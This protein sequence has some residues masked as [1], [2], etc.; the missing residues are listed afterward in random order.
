MHFAFESQFVVK[1]IA[2]GSPSPTAVTLVRATSYL[3]VSPYFYSHVSRPLQCSL[4]FISFHFISLLTLGVCSLWSTSRAEISRALSSA[5]TPSSCRWP[6]SAPRW[7]SSCADSAT[8]T[9][10]RSSTSALTIFSH[11]LCAAYTT[12]CT[13]YR[14]LLSAFVCYFLF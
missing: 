1:L 12:T 6:P 9:H 2:S 11:F 10:S 5:S 3:L 8:C 14:Y 7:N 13:E 4:L